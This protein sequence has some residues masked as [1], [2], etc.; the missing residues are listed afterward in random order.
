VALAVAVAQRLCLRL[1]DWLEDECRRILT[2][3][4][5]KQE[6]KQQLQRPNKETSHPATPSTITP[7]PSQSSQTLSQVDSAANTEDVT[8]A[9]YRIG[10]TD[11]WACKNCKQKD[12]IWYMKQHNCSMSKV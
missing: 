9:I 3:P 2:E 11:T 1:L 7:E 4:I 8:K 12:D 5:D 6:E 10:N